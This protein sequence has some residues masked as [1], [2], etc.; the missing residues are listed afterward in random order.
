MRRVSGLPARGCAYMLP[1]SPSLGL[2]L[3]CTARL[4]ANAWLLLGPSL[5]LAHLTNVE[6]KLS[7]FTLKLWFI[8]YPLSLSSAGAA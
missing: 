8:S 1:L 5:S 3:M 4:A 6:L 2:R 7:V